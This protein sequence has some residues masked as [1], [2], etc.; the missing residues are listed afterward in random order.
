[1][2]EKLFI[3]Y[4]LSS[5]YQFYVLK[6]HTD[7]LLLLYDN[8]KSKVTI[9]EKNTEKKMCMKYSLRKL[10]SELFLIQMRILNFL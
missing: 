2:L 5:Y 6:K 4:F 8:S 10:L 9:K 3:L 1:M 7:T